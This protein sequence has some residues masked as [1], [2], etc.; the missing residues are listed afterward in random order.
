MTELSP[1][2]TAVPDDEASNI[3]ELKGKSGCL[4]PGTE[5]LVIDLETGQAISPNQ[6]GEILIRGPQVTVVV[7]MP[8]DVTDRW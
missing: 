5:A 1:V 7:V 6:P 8:F 2:A 4:L 3:D